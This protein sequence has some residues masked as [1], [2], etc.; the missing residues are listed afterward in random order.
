M[1]GNG[2]ELRTSR[3]F[4]TLE[5]ITQLH[6]HSRFIHCTGCHCT[7]TRESRVCALHG[8]HY[9]CTK[10]VSG[11]ISS[12]KSVLYLHACHYY[13]SAACGCMAM[14]IYI[15]SSQTMKCLCEQLKTAIVLGLITCTHC[16][17]SSE[18]CG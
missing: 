16:V 8:C 10:G 14:N 2:D 15:D 4:C 13:M 9:T 1:S 5:P 7:C 3:E 18:C 11:I 6:M 12:L 17:T